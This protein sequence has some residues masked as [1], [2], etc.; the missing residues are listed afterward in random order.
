MNPRTTARSV[1]DI[2]DRFGFEAPIVTRSA[3]EVEDVAS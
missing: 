2:T 3:A 1:K